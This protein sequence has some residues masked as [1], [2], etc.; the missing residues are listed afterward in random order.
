MPFTVVYDA[1]VLY[2]ASLRDLLIRLARTDR[3]QARWS[4]EILDEMVRGI[5]ADRPDLNPAAMARTRQ[6]MCAAV[7]DCLVQGHQALI[8]S[9][10]LPDPDDRHVLA[11]AIRAGAQ[12]I[13]THN[14]KDFPPP[15]LAPFGI[16]AQSPDD[17]VLHLLELAPAI[18]ASTVQLQ[19]VALT[20]PPQTVWDVLETL[21]ANGL[22]RSTAEIRALL[23]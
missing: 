15:A 16:E 6:L 4:D 19:A 8:D 3:F 12:V 21:A 7:R 2:P 9:L 20:K 18:V 17:F 10:E 5:L 22:V 23:S 1:C 11:A 14:L 13:V